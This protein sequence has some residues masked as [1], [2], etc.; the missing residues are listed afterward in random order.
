MNENENSDLLTVTNYFLVKCRTSVVKCLKNIVL[1]N[2][3]WFYVIRLTP[4]CNRHMH[5][6]TE[7]WEHG[8]LLD[9]KPL[10]RWLSEQEG[11][12]TKFFVIATVN[13]TVLFH[14]FIICF[15]IFLFLCCIIA[16][17]VYTLNAMKFEARTSWILPKS[18]TLDQSWCLCII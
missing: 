11:R 8:V 17:F 4:L 10:D 3:V 5:R 1:M 2:S 12:G 14:L 13:L 18:L 16:A 15:L 7:N 6:Y 9:R